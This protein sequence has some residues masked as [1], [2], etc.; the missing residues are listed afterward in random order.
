MEQVLP[1]QQPAKMAR[2]PRKK[3][4][5]LR[6]WF[7]QKPRPMSKRRFAT[8]IGVTPSYVSQLTSDDPPWPGRELS[9]RIGIVTEG[10]VTPN[11]LAG[12]PP[13]D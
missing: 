6:A 9:Q 5:V 4:N 8:L 13:I 1:E 7:A 2:K 12:Y 10:A 11:D 3:P